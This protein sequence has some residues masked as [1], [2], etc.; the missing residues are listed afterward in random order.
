MAAQT[1][2]L[3]AQRDSR[4]AVK[5]MQWRSA[6]CALL[7]LVC[8]KGKRESSER[9]SECNVDLRQPN[10]SLVRQVL[11]RRQTQFEFDCGT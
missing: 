4:T 5:E 6:A 3:K 1:G 7:A 2:V 9:A 10:H 8:K 11:R